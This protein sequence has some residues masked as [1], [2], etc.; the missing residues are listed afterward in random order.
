MKILTILTGL[1]AVFLAVPV[2]A[3]S[4]PEDVLTR[5]AA[6]DVVIL[7]EVH[8]N[9]GH[10]ARQAAAVAALGPAAMVWEMLTPEA[11][12]RIDGAALPAADTLAAA[13]N[14]ANSGWPSFDMYYPILVA[15]KVPVIG[16]QVPRAKV[17]GVVKGGAS[18]VFGAGAADY[19]LTSPLSAKEQATREAEQNAAHCN[20]MPVD[21]LS[22]L[23]DIQRLRDAVLARAVVAAFDEYGGPVVVI[24]GNGHARNDRGIA[25]YLHQVRPALK[26]F[27]LG[28]SE[29]GQIDGEFG[30]V[31]DSPV[32][33]RPDPCLAF[34]KQG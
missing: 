7:G 3:G 21:R 30:A 19:G 12:A 33:D 27:V 24:T 22:F 26:V 34:Q 11:A 13:L 9:P 5:M 8:D 28:Q 23:V 6:A 15:G 25:V 18:A 31:L 29:G 1:W 16:A 2:L 17:M 4:V 14:W 10:H 32:V 20:A